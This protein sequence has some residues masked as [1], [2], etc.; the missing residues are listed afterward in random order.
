MMAH[1]MR[2][3]KRTVGTQTQA[4]LENSKVIFI[5][6]ATE[7]SDI[8]PFDSRPLTAKEVKELIDRFKPYQVTVE[9]PPKKPEPAPITIDE[10]ICTRKRTRPMSL[11]IAVKRDK[12]GIFCAAKRPNLSVLEDDLRLS[13]SEESINPAS[14]S[15]SSTN[16]SELAGE[17]EH[18]I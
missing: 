14:A 1:Q 11:D 17:V 9:P 4:T 6:V 2:C 5:S 10:Q 15:N 8:E 12:F 16:W 7:F 3:N 13:S 18:N